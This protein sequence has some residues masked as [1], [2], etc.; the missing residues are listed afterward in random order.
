MDLRRVF[1]TLDACAGTNGLGEKVRRSE[2]HEFVG[3]ARCTSTPDLETAV[4]IRLERV[5]RYL[6]QYHGMFSSTLVVFP[7]VRMCLCNFD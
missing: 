7:H 2:I 3:L 6:K 1:V 4:L 5:C